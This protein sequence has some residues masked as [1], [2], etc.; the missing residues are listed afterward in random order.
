MPNSEILFKYRPLATRLYFPRVYYLKVYMPVYKYHIALTNCPN[1][2]RILK[3]GSVVPKI[4]PNIETHKHNSLK[5]V[6]VVYGNMHVFE[7]C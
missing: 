6:S 7:V 2:K 5:N 1:S 3:I 4:T